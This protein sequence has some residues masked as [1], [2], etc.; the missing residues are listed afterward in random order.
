MVAQKL[1]NMIS[2]L[3]LTSDITNAEEWAITQS[4]V[5]IIDKILCEELERVES[6]EKQIQ[7]YDSV[8]FKLVS[9]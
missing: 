6:V 9:K 7:V 4:A 2:F 1:W 8:G 3:E 5:R